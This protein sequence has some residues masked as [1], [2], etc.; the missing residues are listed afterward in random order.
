MRDCN[1]VTP[2]K[3]GAASSSATVL[4]TPLFGAASAMLG[5]TWMGAGVIV[6]ELERGWFWNLVKFQVGVG[7]IF[8]ILGILKG[9]G[10]T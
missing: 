4:G 7:C 8:I 9:K 3:P 10:S 2:L 5:K 1:H 6:E